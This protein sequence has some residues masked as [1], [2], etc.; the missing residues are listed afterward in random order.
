[1]QDLS[2]LFLTLNRLPQKFTDFHYETLKKAIGDTNLLAISREPMPCDYLLDDGIPG[3]QNIY[4]QMLR[5]AKT[6]DTDYIAIAEDDCLYPADH[7]TLRG[8]GFVYNQHRWALFTWDA[9]MYSWRNRFSNSTLI[10]PRLLMIKALEERFAK[11]GDNWPP[12][13]VGELGRSM[14]DKG[15]G[16]THYPAETKW[17]KTGVVQFNHVHAHEDRQ[18]RMRKSFGNIRAIEIPYWGKSMDLVKHYD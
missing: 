17:S 4:R 13:L 11:W 16:V 18:R 3:Y 15:L 9:Q 5:G 14:V 1:M 2:V 10:A 12:N 7:F 8:D 6:L